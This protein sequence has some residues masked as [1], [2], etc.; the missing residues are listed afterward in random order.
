MDN[1]NFSKIYFRLFIYKIIVLKKLELSKKEIL[2][3]N[4]RQRMK[5][6][7]GA[8]RS[9]IIDGQK[10]LEEESKRHRN[11]KECSMSKSQSDTFGVPNGTLKGLN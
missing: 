8:E 1:L 9:K 7:L 10:T 4:H 3:K 2:K 5:T 6:C 11:I